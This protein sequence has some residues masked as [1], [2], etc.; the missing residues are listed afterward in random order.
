MYIYGFTSLTFEFVYPSFIVS[1]LCSYVKCCFSSLFFTLCDSVKTKHEFDL[2]FCIPPPDNKFC[3]CFLYWLRCYVCWVFLIWRL[4]PYAHAIYMMWYVFFL[5]PYAWV[6][7]ASFFSYIQVCLGVEIYFFFCSHFD[8]CV[9][10]LCMLWS[11]YI[12]WPHSF[13]KLYLTSV[14]STYRFVCLILLLFIMSG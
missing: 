8:V 6:C 7:S 5:Y 1:A 12:C 2:F 3:L 9:T 11:Q 4:L 13:T 10:W 14:L